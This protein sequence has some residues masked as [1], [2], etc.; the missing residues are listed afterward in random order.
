MKKVILNFCFF[1][2]VTVS[3]AQENHS[4]D[5]LNAYSVEELNTIKNDSPENYQLLTYAL[6]T[7]GY[8]IID[9][10]TEKQIDVQKSITLPKGKFNFATLG[11]KITDDAQFIGISGTN[12]ILVIKAMQVI[13]YEFA[14][15]K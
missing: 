2:L 11:F 12:K 7:G 9:K 4:K 13:K 1:L 15:K 5:L 8:Y 14:N 3:F 10:P 6:S